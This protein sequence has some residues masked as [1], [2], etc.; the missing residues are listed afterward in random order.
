MH[1]KFY[2][3]KQKEDSMMEILEQGQVDLVEGLLIPLN[4]LQK[5]FIRIKGML[6]EISLELLQEEKEDKT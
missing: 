4:N 3:I 1:T 6:L 5:I 2:P